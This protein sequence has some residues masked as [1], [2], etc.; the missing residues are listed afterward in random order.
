MKVYIKNHDKH[1]LWAGDAW[2]TA[3]ELAREYEPEKAKEIIAKRW[4]KGIRKYKKR[5]NGYILCYTPRPG[6]KTRE[7]LGRWVN[8]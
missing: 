4:S 3:I 2:T 1:E 7:E 5:G 8:V 6:I